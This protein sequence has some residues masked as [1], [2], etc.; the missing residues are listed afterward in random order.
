MSQVIAIALL[1]KVPKNQLA[2][3]KQLFDQAYKQAGGVIS[4]QE[5][6]KFYV[7][8]NFFDSYCSL[9]LKDSQFLHLSL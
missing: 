8:F 1:G 2:Q 7:D 5:G 6:A 3:I 9:C 4:L